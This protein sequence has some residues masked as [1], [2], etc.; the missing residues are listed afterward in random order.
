MSRKKTMALV[1]AF[2]VILLVL[3]T[4][5][6][7]EVLRALTV[8]L[9][10]LHIPARTKLIIVIFGAFFAHIVEMFLVRCCVLRTR[11][12]SGRRHAGRSQSLLHD[13]LS[14][15]LGGNIHNPRIRRCRSRWRIMIACRH[16]GSKRSSFDW[17]VG[18]IHLYCDGALLERCQ[19]VK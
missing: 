4:V 9:P 13:S 15:L 19:Q 16:G 12:L 7:Y 8:G 6:H 14:V 11:P 1:G 3:T 18:L 2:C 5:I 10:M 17:M